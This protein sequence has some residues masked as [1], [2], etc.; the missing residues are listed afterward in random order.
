LSH[1]RWQFQSLTYFGEEK[2]GRFSSSV[3]KWKK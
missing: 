2:H 3:D 1:K